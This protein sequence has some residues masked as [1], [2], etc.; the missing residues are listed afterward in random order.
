MNRGF[1]RAAR[2]Y[3]VRL[4]DPSDFPSLPMIYRDSLD[5]LNG[6]KLG[7]E[8]KRVMS[9]LGFRKLQSDENVG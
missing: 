3:A 4:I 9:Y 5:S 1:Y 8:L 2:A 6:T 7:D